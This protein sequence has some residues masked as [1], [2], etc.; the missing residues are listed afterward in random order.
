MLKYKGGG[1]LPGVPAR[2]LSD[3]EVSRFGKSGLLK[4]KLYVEEEKENKKKIAE[5]NDGRYQS[6]SEDTT[7]D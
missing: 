1:F 5:V 4:S 2:D 7:R 3:E 6:V